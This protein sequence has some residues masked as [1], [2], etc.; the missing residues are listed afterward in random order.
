MNRVY[1][2]E[3]EKSF[4]MSK[5]KF[6]EL[7]RTGILA[8]THKD[9]IKQCWVEDIK[10]NN[11][12][13]RSRLR[14]TKNISETSAKFEYTSKFYLVNNK[15][16]ECNACIS[17]EEYTCLK[18]IYK[19]TPDKVTT[20]MRHYFYSISEPTKEIIYSA[21]FYSDNDEI[22]IEAEFKN[23]DICQKWEMPAWLRENI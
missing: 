6:T 8:I 11:I 14:M 9:L 23:N 10:I 18:V 1:D 7:V 13:K 4:K 19:V 12:Q 20:K 17:Q 22:T 16:I 15:R 5:S 2:T 21:D 3:L